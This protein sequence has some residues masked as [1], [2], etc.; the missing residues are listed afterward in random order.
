MY[1]AWGGLLGCWCVTLPDWRS[2]QG[3]DCPSEALA[4]KGNGYLPVQVG[5]LSAY[6]SGDLLTC[7]SEISLLG[8]CY[9]WLSFV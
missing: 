6:P 8:C 9:A 2:T 1:F 5:I 3:M 4:V 7:L